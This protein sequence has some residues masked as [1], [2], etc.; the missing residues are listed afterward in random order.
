[1]SVR[2]IHNPQFRGRRQYAELPRV[3]PIMIARGSSYSSTTTGNLD[4]L[5]QQYAMFLYGTNSI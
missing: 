4:L 3:W 5:N 2:Y 1:M